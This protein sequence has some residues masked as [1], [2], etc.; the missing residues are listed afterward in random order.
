VP[1]NIVA[2]GIDAWSNNLKDENAHRQLAMEMGGARLD[3][4]ANGGFHWLSAREE[5]ADKVLVASAVY[6]FNERNAK[7]PTAM[8]GQQ[9]HELEI[10]P[11]PYPREHSRYRA[12]EDWEFL[13]RFNGHPLASQKVVLETQNGSRAEFL[14]NA[15][16]VVKVHFPD[17]FKPEEETPATAMRSRMRGADFVLVAEQTEAGK[18]YVTAFNSNYAPDALDKRS[19][20]IGLG[21]TLLGM[22]GGIPLLK[23]GK[24]SKNSSSDVSRKEEA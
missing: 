14:G 3:K 4:P 8:F 2:S 11:Q 24:M 1:Q 6:A 13:V 12:N 19:M 22:L 18:T 20:A 21:F 10:A 9:K 15:Q 7:D 17:D 23:Q 16:G 5:Q